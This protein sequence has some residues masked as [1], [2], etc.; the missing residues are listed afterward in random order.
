MN[1]KRLLSVGWKIALVL[2]IALAVIYRL[3]FSPVP[4]ESSPV[5]AGPIAAEVMG[6]GTLEARIQAIVSAKI[7]GRL[8]DVLEDQGN[9]VKKGQLLAT[10]DDGDY[11]QQVEMAKAEMETAK[12]SVNR[13]AADVISAQATAVHARA[14]YSRIMPLAESKVVSEEDFDNAIQQRDVADSQLRRTELA[15]VETDCQLI[16]AEAALKYYEE[17]LADTKIVAPFDGLIIRRDRDPGAIV[18]PGSS[19]MQI[20]STE[21]MWVSAWVDESA[22][23]AL[24]VEQTARVVFR[25]ESKKSYK[26]AVARISPLADRETREFLVDVLVKELPKTWAV[27]QRAEVY[28]QT[29]SKDNALLV[30]SKAITWQKGKPGLFISNE[31]HAKWVD[32]ETGLQGKE[33]VEILSGLKT[34]DVVIWPPDSTKAIPENR[35]VRTK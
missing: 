20:I 12:A 8:S 32:V 23:A 19:I 3:R 4:V 11:R 9:R 21:Q 25:S 10:L 6:T 5:K 35:A 15:K 34:G 27:G 17:K 22:M 28:I 7:S 13:A 26:G 2:I 14:F 1:T 24:A 33:S 30:P 16:K 18:V 31:G 29:A